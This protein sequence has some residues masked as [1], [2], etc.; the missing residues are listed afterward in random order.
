MQ[1]FSWVERHVII[2][3][4]PYLTADETNKRSKKEMKK[5]KSAFVKHNILILSS[6]T[7]THNHS[8]LYSFFFVCVRYYKITRCF[9]NLWIVEFSTD[10]II[11]VF[12]RF[13]QFFVLFLLSIGIMFPFPFCLRETNIFFFSVAI[14][15]VEMRFQ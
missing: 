10:R 3:R 11:E 4:L 2:G 13:S 8:Y 6:Y 1:S 15:D 9:H 5:K 7:V 14:L 12:S